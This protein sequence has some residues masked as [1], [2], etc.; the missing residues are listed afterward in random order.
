M[1]KER[2]EKEIDKAMKEK[3]RK[4]KLIQKEIQDNEQLQQKLQLKEKR[5]RKA[6]K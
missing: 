6:N 2:L 1:I 3:E 4:L 5:L